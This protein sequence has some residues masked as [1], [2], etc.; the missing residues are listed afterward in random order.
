MPGVAYLFEAFLILLIDYFYILFISSYSSFK[1]H[2]HHYNFFFFS[3]TPLTKPN[4]QIMEN[5]IEFPW[6]NTGFR[7]NEKI[8]F[9][10][11]PNQA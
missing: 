5:K 1:K 10:V 9:K 6:L 8:P 7:E 3:D 2:K 11:Y 4:Y